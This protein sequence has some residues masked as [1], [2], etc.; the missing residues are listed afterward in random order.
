VAGGYLVAGGSRT[1]RDGGA[2]GGLAVL[3]L[4]SLP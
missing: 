1:D 3:R 2:T 4:A